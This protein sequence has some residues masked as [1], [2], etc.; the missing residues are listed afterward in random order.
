ME[1]AASSAYIRDM[2]INEKLLQFLTILM[3]YSWNLDRAKKSNPTGLNIFNE[4]VYIDR[5]FTDKIS[6]GVVAKQFNVNKS[7][8]LRLFRGNIGLTVNNYILQNVFLWQKM[9]CAFRI[10]RLM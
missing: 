5:S 2:K 9:S 7:Y 1:T 6:L 3:E 10:K 8:L 4:T